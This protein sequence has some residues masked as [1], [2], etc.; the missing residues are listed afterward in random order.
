MLVLLGC[1][2]EVQPSAAKPGW[3]ARQS[4]YSKLL[5]DLV[6]DCGLKAVAEEAT[7]RECTV[8][9]KVAREN[10]CTYCNLDID[11]ET[12]S[13]IR[14]A[15]LMMV[16]DIAGAWVPHEHYQYARA[17]TLVREYH[18]FKRYLEFN[19]KNLPAVLI[20]GR[21]HLAG[22]RNL[23]KGWPNLGLLCTGARRDDC[24]ER[25]EETKLFDFSLR[26]K[27]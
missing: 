11:L 26:H 1:C 17:W 2:H 9:Q 4:T 22:L 7:Q 24:C 20:C 27:S 13:R 14:T 15:P 10:A 25:W 12:Q 3:E 6:I 19:P 23:F 16:D 8:A 18:M 5:R 21:L